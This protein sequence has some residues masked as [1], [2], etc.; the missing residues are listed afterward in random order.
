MF[1]RLDDWA[2][3]HKDGLD[4]AASKEGLKLLWFATGR[5]DFLIGRSRQTVALFKKDGFQPVFKETDGA[6]TWIN[7]QKYFYELAPQL[8]Q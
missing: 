1:G 3:K 4:D 6:H 2:S 5:E 8:F 7:W